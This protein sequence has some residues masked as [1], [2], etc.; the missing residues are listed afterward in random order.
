MSL[1]NQIKRLLFIDSLIHNKA[2]G[3]PQKFAEKNRL[4]RSHLMNILKDMKEL[5]YPI[6]YS[7][8]ANTYYYAEK[9]KVPVISVLGKHILR[10]NEMKQITI[11]LNI[12]NACFSEINIFEIC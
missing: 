12:N 11:E 8:M 4:S 10:K 3:T 2:T 6:K 9:E 5:G 1:L 7:R